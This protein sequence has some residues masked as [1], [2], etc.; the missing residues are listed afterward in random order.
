MTLVPVSLSYTMN[1]SKEPNVP[2]V[3]FVRDY[4][5]TET[6]EIVTL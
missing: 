6:G 5:N 2:I 3:I 1:V 4:E